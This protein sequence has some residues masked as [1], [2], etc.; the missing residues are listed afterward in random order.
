MTLDD[1]K[2]EAAQGK[3]SDFDRFMNAIP[4][5]PVAKGDELFKI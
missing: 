2:P 1:L 5:A 3:R 4:Y